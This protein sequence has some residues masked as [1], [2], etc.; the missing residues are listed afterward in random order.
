MQAL[1]KDPDREQRSV[2][3][4]LDR[5]EIR[6]ADDRSN[7]QVLTSLVSAVTTPPN[8]APITTPTAISTTFPR[9]MNFLNPSSIRA[10]RIFECAAN[11]R[12]PRRQVKE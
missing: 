1:M 10:P 9:R 4:Q 11:V 12:Q 2:D 8:A 3:G 5:R 6:L 7:K